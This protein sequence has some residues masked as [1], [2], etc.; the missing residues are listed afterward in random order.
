[1]SGKAPTIQVKNF[2]DANK[3][4]EDLAFSTTDLNSAM[5]MQASIFAHYGKLAADAAYQ[6]DMIENLLDNSEANLM[7]ALR[8]EFV[9]LGE[10]PTEAQLRSL[11]A[12]DERIKAI[13][14]TLAKARR[15]EAVC[16][17]A[18]DAFRQKRDML[19]QTG[20]IQREEMKG[21]LFI[22]EK[23]QA[24]QNIERLQQSVLGRTAL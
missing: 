21:E 7:K 9:K 14:V 17:N 4:R 10:K 20:L 19:I 6:T 8:D 22:R 16:K 5:Q 3:L 24:D 1:M 2:I 18:V 12:S 23:S 11:I 15:I 13:K